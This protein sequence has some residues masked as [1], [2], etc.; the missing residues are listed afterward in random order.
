MPGRTKTPQD[1]VADVVTACRRRCC[2]CYALRKDGTEKRG[3]IAHLDHDPSNNAVANLAF[4]C[5]EHHDQYDSRTSQSKGLTIEEVKRYRTELL[6]FVDRTVPPGD[7]EIV[8]TLMTALDRPAFRTPFHQESSLPRFRVAIA[9]TIE[10]L[11]TGRTPQ[12]IQ[13]PSKLQIRDAAL[14]SNVDR[15]V[16]ALVALR[17][18]FDDLLR[19]GEIKHCGCQTADCPTHFL[20][21]EAI[22]EM[23]SRRRTL[24][25]L[26]HVLNPQIPEGFYDDGVW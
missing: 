9:E 24:L 5:L 26:A 22:R 17:A 4:L 13:T 1:V 7:A 18:S 10:T 15:I 19:R 25:V 2:V 6:A 8:A 14:R 23:D 20:S 12:G 21:K 3:Q 11:N 16:Q